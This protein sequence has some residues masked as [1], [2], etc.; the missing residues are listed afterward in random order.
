MPRPRALLV[1]GL[2]A[3][4]GTWWRVAPALEARGW[5]VERATLPGHGGRP[6]GE[7]GAV[8]DLA[9]D[10]AQRYAG[11]PTLVVGHSIGAVV[12]LELAARHPA[13]LVGVVLEDPPG[14]GRTRRSRQDAEERTRED[15]NALA[16][17]HAAITELL[18]GHPTWT[19]RDARSVVEGRL[20]AA[21]EVA[22][23]F[24]RHLSWDLPARVAACPV[25][26]GLVAAVGR[27][28]ALGE[29]D[30]AHLLR[31]LPAAVVTEVAAGHHVH[32][33]APG[34]WVDAVDSFGR[35]L[36]PSPSAGWP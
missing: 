14:P 10:V 24:A 13:H 33:D 36:R 29:P 31:T 19:R 22:A 2:L 18:H 26:V 7:V 1:H 6:L 30:R 25:P 35:D 5:Q 4:P 12:A 17:P 11:R 34:A 27:Y 20:G 16:D 3:G 9:D 23:S 8:A 28:S 32:R 21:P 15:V